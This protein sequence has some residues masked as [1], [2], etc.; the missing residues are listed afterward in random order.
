MANIAGGPGLIPGPG[1]RSHMLQLMILHAA[2]NTRYSQ[3][4]KNIFFKKA[5]FV[6]SR[7]RDQSS[8]YLF[9]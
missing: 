8:A 2:T 4:N 5:I 6:E 1:T 9:S 3:I 7:I